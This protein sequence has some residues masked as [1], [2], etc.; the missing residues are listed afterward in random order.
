VSK[1]SATGLAIVPN[2]GGRARDV[3]GRFRERLIFDSYRAGAAVAQRLPE[4]SLP[5]L[6]RVA[7]RFGGW[8]QPAHR[9][10]AERHQQRVARFA[11][12]AVHPASDVFEQYGRYWLEIL[13]LPADIRRG[14]VDRYWT[15]DGYENIEKAV[16]RG[17]GAILALP[18]LGGWEWAA[19]WMAEQGHH[20]LAVVEALEPPALLEWFREQREAMGLEIVALGPDVANRVLR[21]LRDNRIVC[22]LSDR[23]LAGDG[24]EVQFFG[25]RTTLPGGPATLALRTGAA[26]LPVAV[27]F[28]PGRRHHGVVRPALALEREGRLRDDVARITQALAR[29]FESL[30]SA[31]PEQWHLLQP[32][33]PSDRDSGSLAP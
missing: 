28:G 25:E 8:L 11:G 24:V 15:I 23:D 18:H 22:L 32:N 12:E 17:N 4:A 33:W 16:A 10:M 5:A 21:A 31:H 9:A 29:E 1:V 3:P 30:I 6:A 7:G 13:R 19:A 27:Y 20:M 14:V 26:I 2:G